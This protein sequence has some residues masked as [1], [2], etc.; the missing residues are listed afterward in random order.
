MW[1]LR[2]L[3]STQKQ[4]VISII[5]DCLQFLSGRSISQIIVDLGVQCRTDRFKMV[6]FE[7]AGFKIVGLQLAQTAYKERVTTQETR[8]MR[9]SAGKGTGFMSVKFCFSHSVK[10]WMHV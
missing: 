3:C 6:R 9:V 8:K 5:T 1:F 4:D 2:H 7:R 10:H